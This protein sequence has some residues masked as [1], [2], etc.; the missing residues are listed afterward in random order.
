MEKVANGVH[1]IGG[2]VNA[3]LVDGDEGV[4]LIDTGLPKKEGLIENGLAAIGRSPSDIVAILVTH[5]HVD[6]IGGAAEIKAASGA[7]LYASHRDTKA[8]E[9]AAPIPAPPMMKGPMKVMLRLM[10]KPTPVA[11]DHSISEVDDSSLPGDLTAVDTPGHT[12]GHTSFLLARDGG[13]LFVGDAAANKRGTVVPGFPNAGGGPL[14]AESIRH[15]GEFEF[16][17][18]VFGHSDPITQNASAA[19]RAFSG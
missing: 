13:I 1:A 12:P 16:D 5:S 11:V 17:V 9:G 4:V 6:H 10:P 15:I 7:S 8:I 19:F 3:F 2:Y 14:V 18:A